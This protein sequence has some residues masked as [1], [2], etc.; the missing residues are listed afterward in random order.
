MRIFEYLPRLLHSK[1]AVV[2]GERATIG[3]SN[4]D[5]RSFFLNYELNLFTQDDWLCSR[6]RAVFLDDLQQSEE[7][8]PEQWK[9]RFW[10]RKALELV[11]WLARRLL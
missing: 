9:T 11:G 3:T 5:Y 6:L 1:T 2:D 4:I 8:L 10:G 7:I